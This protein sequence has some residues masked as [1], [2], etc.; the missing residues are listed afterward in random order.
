MQQH[1]MQ[2]ITKVSYEEMTYV[3]YVITYQ[4]RNSKSPDVLLLVYLREIL[5]M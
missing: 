1:S 5:N 4:L 3:K 2:Q